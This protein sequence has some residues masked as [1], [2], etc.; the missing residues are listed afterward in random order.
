MGKRGGARPNSGRKS[1]AEEEQLI[2]KLS[3]LEPLAHKKL[4]EAINEGKDWA[5]KMFFEYMYGKPK[6]RVDLD[7]ALKT[8]ISFKE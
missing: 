4:Q 1:K 7:A 5:I 6:Q 8:T 2:S 3:P